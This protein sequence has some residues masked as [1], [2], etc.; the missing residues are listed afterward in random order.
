MSSA[1]VIVLIFPLLLLAVI[2]GVIFL[3]IYLSKKESKWLGLIL[4]IITLAISMIVV[5]SMADR[6]AISGA[7]AAVIYTFI[8]MNIPTVTLLIIYKVA[9]RKQNRRRDIEKM[10]VQDL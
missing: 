6:E 8:I 7:I 9:R 4:P 1:V 2:V 3:Q 5:M 10:S